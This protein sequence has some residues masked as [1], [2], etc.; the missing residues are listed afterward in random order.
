[1]GFTC[2][3]LAFRRY[4]VK[5]GAE[6]ADISNKKGTYETTLQLLNRAHEIHSNH[7]SETDQIFIITLTALGWCLKE[8]GQLDESLALLTEGLDIQDRLG[9]PNLSTYATTCNALADLH[10]NLHNY[11]KAHY[12]FEQAIDCWGRFDRHVNAGIA[13]GNMANLANRQ[14][15]FDEALEYASR[16]LRIDES[17]LGVDHPDLAFPLTCVGESCIGLKSYEDAIEVLEHAFQLRTDNDVPP[18]N[19]AWTQWLLGRALVESDRNAPLGYQ[20]I[21]QARVILQSLGDATVDELKDVESWLAE[22]IS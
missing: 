8:L 7:L 15:R 18:G 10:L 9:N 22:N 11:D 13:L 19:F 12:Y 4:P 5:P 2:L 21:E 17:M 14:K 20:Y 3:K 1:M 16:G 6:L